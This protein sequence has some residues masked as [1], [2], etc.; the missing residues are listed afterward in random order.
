LVASDDDL[1]SSPVFFPL[2]KYRRQD[3]GDDDEEDFDGILKT[4][5]FALF[6]FR[7]VDGANLLATTLVVAVAANRYGKDVM[8]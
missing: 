1:L 7:N 8:V 5:L 2:L 3:G 6:A 4:F